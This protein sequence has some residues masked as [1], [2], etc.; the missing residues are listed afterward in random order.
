[1][2]KLI[3][4]EVLNNYECYR[5]GYCELQY[6]LYYAKA[7]GYTSGVYGW[8]ADIYLFDNLAIVTGYRPFGQQI[9]SELVK[10]YEEKA[11]KIVHNYDV[12]YVSYYKYEQRR[13]K[14]NKLI[15]KFI[16]EVKGA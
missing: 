15:E 4:K 3:K 10:K 12:S 7:I 16:E 1:M 9:N 14:V 8:N 11:R 2:M 5:V 13:K 6:L